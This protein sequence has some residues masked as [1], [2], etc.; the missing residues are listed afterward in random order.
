MEKC[1][2]LV[3]VTHELLEKLEMERCWE[4]LKNNLCITFFYKV[5]MK[6]NVQNSVLSTNV[7]KHS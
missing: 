7:I 5:E 4:N 2:K 6:D 3:S 1:E